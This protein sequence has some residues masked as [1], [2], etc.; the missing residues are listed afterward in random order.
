MKVQEV[1][2]SM[3]DHP[4][5]LLFFLQLADILEVRLLSLLPCLYFSV[6]TSVHQLL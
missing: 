3:L 5:P 4:L 6:G 1:A 2:L